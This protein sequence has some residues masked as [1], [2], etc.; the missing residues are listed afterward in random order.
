MKCL[1]R[2]CLLTDSEC[3]TTTAILAPRNNNIDYIYGL[4]KNL[5]EEFETYKS[6]HFIDCKNEDEVHFP[7]ELSVIINIF[8]FN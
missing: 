3:F 8:L 1:H 4:L 7:V 5:T 6:L 2:T